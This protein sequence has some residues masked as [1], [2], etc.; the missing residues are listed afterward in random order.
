MTTGSIS[1]AIGGD[2]SSL[3][4]LLDTHDAA[5]DELAALIRRGP[6]TRHL[7]LLHIERRL[8]APAGPD[9]L[10]GFARRLPATLDDGPEVAAVLARLY[11]R[12]AR[13]RTGPLPAWRAAG[14][15]AAVEVE[16][17]RAEIAASPDALAAEPFGE[18]LLQALAPGLVE[19]S[20]A[21]SDP[22][23]DLAAGLRALAGRAD[24][25]LQRAALD[26]LRQ[27]LWRCRLTPGEARALL[28]GLARSP[29]DDIASDALRE[30]AE[31]WSLLLPVPALA[32]G[33]LLARPGATAAALEHAAR[34]RLD[35]PI[36]GAIEDPALAP[37]LRQRAMVLAGAFAARGHVAAMIAI[38]VADPLLFGPP[39][40][41]FLRAQHRLGHF[42]TPDDVP[43]LAQVCLASGELDAGEVARLVF[44]VRHAFC[45]ELAT[46]AVDDPSWPRRAELLVAL[47]RGPQGA[48]PLA[49]GAI[50]EAALAAATEPRVQR[51]LIQ[52][53]G[54]LGHVAA[55]AAVLAHLEREPHAV[56]RALRSIGGAAAIAALVAGA[57]RARLR[58]LRDAALTLAWQL[59]EREPEARAAVR[60]ALSTGDVPR[61]LEPSLGARASADELALLHG[62][63]H[64]AP[65]SDYLRR[66]AAVAGGTE[67]E[68]LC[69]L[70]L[71]LVSDLATGKEART[72]GWYGEERPHRALHSEAARSL[73][74]DV[75]AALE[76]MGQR[77][78]RAGL[79]R[80]RAVLDASGERAAGPLVISAMAR[81][82]LERPDLTRDETAVLLRMLEPE[83]DRRVFPAIHRLLRRSESDLRKVVIALLARDGADDLLVNLTLLTAEDDI[84]TIR[85]AILAIGSLGAR[86]TRC[87]AA[88]AAC[89]E[90]RNMNI[91]K[92][93]AESLATAGGPEAVARLMF[94]LG[95]HDNPGFRTAL[96]AALRAILGPAYAATVVAAL[97]ATGADGP[98]A[99]RRSDLLIEAL[100][101]TLASDDAVALCRRDEPFAER[102]HAA[103]TSARIALASR[104]LLGFT[105]ALAA[106][107]PPRGRILAGDPP[108]QLAQLVAALAAGGFDA[109]AAARVLA[110]SRA[111]GASWPPAEL[112]ALRRF[113]FEWCARLDE[114]ASAHERNLVEPAVQHGL[115]AHAVEPLGLE[116]AAVVVLLARLAALTAPT[117]TER[118]ALARRIPAILAVL[119]SEPLDDDVHLAA[120]QLL[121]QAVP[122]VP[123]PT[124]LAIARDVRA[125]PE[126]PNLTG[127]DPFELLRACGALVTR[128]DLDRALR[129]ARHTPDPA[130]L[131]RRIL[132][133]SF[134]AD[135]ST[136]PQAVRDDLAHTARR[137]DPA[138]LAGLRA[139]LRQ[140]TGAL[141]SALIDAYVVAHD[142]N[143]PAPRRG[144][145]STAPP[146]SSSSRRPPWRAG[147]APPTSTSRAPG[148][149]ASGS[150]RCSL[151][152]RPSRG[153]RPRSRCSAGPNRPPRRPPPRPTCAAP[154]SSPLRRR[155][156]PRC[157]AS[158]ARGSSKRCAIVTP[159]RD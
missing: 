137:P 37:G 71:R 7:A 87:A 64:D 122:S 109:D 18:R 67:W 92:A 104:D 43:P 83:V 62:A 66:V 1:A 118:A 19:A 117:A 114:P 15:P 90:H 57:D 101:G 25:P 151:H 23:S 35:G 56:L 61:D 148:R 136:V 142:A 97:A 103:I 139:R 134:P 102:L 3:A 34:W 68:L 149:C 88:L 54:E 69:D 110:A 155:W 85:Q 93:A 21:A 49:T 135:A 11:R 98:D 39:L 128:A 12:L 33:E 94:W 32:L 24:P 145:C 30:L 156:R 48:T 127:N 6:A 14:L 147:L 152:L 120:V 105:I 80:P 22:A 119:R 144:R 78:H 100:D 79:L 76:A 44:P 38:A 72:E 81:A 154:P 73:P 107:P 46:A 29:H 16:W 20:G 75:R 27:G 42:V 132:R 58:P 143:R 112:A 13:W 140:P 45:A 40:L 10:A 31:P 115:A 108:S 53:L 124:R 96:I 113:W 123:P 99:A 106:A 55:E 153:T 41:Q 125:L 50:L 51:A 146:P 116:R 26:Q 47:G 129:C 52:A 157:S 131:E 77:W 141:I 59:S 86:A 63:L 17:L 82:L 111:P 133:Q 159:A 74:H 5:L 60:R 8:G 91:K 65:T 2:L 4:H 95:H 28:I 130:A 89:L 126:R 121:A 36:R 84:E 138:E 70:L 150:L 9:T 158:V